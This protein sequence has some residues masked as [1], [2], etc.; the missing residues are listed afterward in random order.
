MYERKGGIIMY[1]FIAHYINMDTD[2]KVS[3]KIEIDSQFFNS[4]KEIYMYAMARAYDLKF[5]EECFDKLEFI[6]C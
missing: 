5:E 3:K 2:K 4:E 1:L 6:A